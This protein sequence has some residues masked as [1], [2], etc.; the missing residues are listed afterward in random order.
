LKKVRI[1]I[2]GLIFGFGLAACAR[3]QT[4]PSNPGIPATAT[5]VT[6][7]PVISPSPTATVTL[8]PSPL[9]TASPTPIPSRTVSPTPRT[10]TSTPCNAKTGNIEFKQLTTSWLPI[11]L[12][13]RVYTPP[14]YNQN[15]DQRYPVLY[16]IHGY[17]YND[18]QWDRLGADEIADKLIS[19]GQISPF[20]IVMPHDSD[21]NTLPPKNHFG[22]ALVFGLI[23]TI[24]TDYRTL[25]FRD[26]R[27]IGGISRG[28]NWAL[29]LGLSHWSF[30]GAIG[31]HSAPFFVSDGP[32]KVK[33]WLSAIPS[34]EFPRIYL[35]V[36]DHDKWIDHI[37][38]FE[39]TLDE[40]N[41]PHE[42]YL[43]PGNHDEPYWASHTE[44]Y[45]RWYTQ[46]W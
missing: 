31:G 30:F 36:G 43:F 21:H 16:L 1:I 15:L 10:P 37:I 13:Y 4:Y 12:D 2:C 19:T 33:G 5:R 45:I 7:L 3:S 39:E 38:R 22:E 44:H 8:T 23:A 9:P 25:P 14:C 20:I 18:D 40:F 46:D 17:G 34:G 42:L 41:V 11:P 6:S 32:P 35:D 27:A 24:D 29:R 28:G 26:Y